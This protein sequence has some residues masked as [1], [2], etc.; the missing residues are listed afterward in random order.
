M[1]DKFDIVIDRYL[2]YRGE[3]IGISTWLYGAFEKGT[4]RKGKKF[5]KN[6]Y[7]TFGKFRVRKAD[8]RDSGKR[9]KFYEFLKENDI[10]VDDA[11]I[12]EVAVGEQYELL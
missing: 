4:I 1:I 5:D 6:D 2:S 7:L 11:R 10:E 3:E 12:P 8:L 9:Q